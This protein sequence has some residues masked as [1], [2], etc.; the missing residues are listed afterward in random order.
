[1]YTI[2]AVTYYLDP[3]IGR[4]SHVHFGQSFFA[5]ATN[6][7]LLYSFVLFLSPGCFALYGAD[8]LIEHE[9][10]VL[11]PRMTEVQKY[12]GLSVEGMKAKIVPR[13]LKEVIESKFHTCV[14]LC[15]C[16]CATFA[17][18][19]SIRVAL[20]RIHQSHF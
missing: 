15:L 6:H 18:C 12:P 17:R 7:S 11:T 4:F 10:G 5:F 2:R 14:C 16:L 20:E 1:V 19:C 8:F 13:M 3:R 9:N